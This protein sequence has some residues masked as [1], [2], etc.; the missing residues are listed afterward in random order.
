VEQNLPY[1]ND[2]VYQ[3]QKDDHCHFSFDHAS[4]TFWG[5]LCDR[6]KL[7]YSLFT[8]DILMHNIAIKD[9]A[10]KKYFFAIDFYW[11]R[12]ALNK[13]QINVLYV[14]LRAYLG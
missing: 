6:Q 3:G 1:S 13:P 9:I 7:V 2:P 10:I 11:P 14:S 4:T 8:P 12:S 5:F